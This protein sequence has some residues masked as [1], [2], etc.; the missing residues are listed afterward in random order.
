MT[1]VAGV[2]YWV[3]FYCCFF[4]GI[5]LLRFSNSW[6]LGWV[7]F[8]EGVSRLTRE[9]VSTTTSH[10]GSTRTLLFSNWDLALTRLDCLWLQRDVVIVRELFRKEQY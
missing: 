9:R 7:S 2:G 6:D 8:L 10:H 5:F 1:G 3:F 4:L